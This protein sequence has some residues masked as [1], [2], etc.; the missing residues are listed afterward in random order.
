MINFAIYLT[1]ICGALASF[2][3]LFRS[4][5]SSVLIYRELSALRQR[6]G[7]AITPPIAPRPEAG[8]RP[9]NVNTRPGYTQATGYFQRPR[10][11]VSVI[12]AGIPLAA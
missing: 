11:A 2:V 8:T 10:P 6:S 3:V 1:V 7:C 4:A 5:K 12:T 9:R